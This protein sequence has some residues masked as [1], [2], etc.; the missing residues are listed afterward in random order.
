MKIVNA[1]RPIKKSALNSN[2]AVLSCDPNECQSLPQPQRQPQRQVTNPNN[3][4][5]RNQQQ[6]SLTFAPPPLVKAPPSGSESKESNNFSLLSNDHS[7]KNSS[8]LS[9]NRGIQKRSPAASPSSSV[10]NRPNG[11]VSQSSQG[12]KGTGCRQCVNCLAD[13][14]GKCNYCLDKPKFGGPNTL[15]KKCIQKKC[16]LIQTGGSVLPRARMIANKQIN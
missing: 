14:C 1:N 2:R 3:F 12:R 16:L 13:D 10:L 7:F 9:P 15:K 8:D 6:E 4:A 11:S 5:R